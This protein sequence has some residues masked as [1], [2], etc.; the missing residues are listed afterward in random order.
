MKKTNIKFFL[1]FIL[2]LNFFQLY[3]IAK[4]AQIARTIA[5]K[6]ITM[7]Y[8]IQSKNR[9]FSLYTYFQNKHHYTFDYTTYTDINYQYMLFCCG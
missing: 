7:K 1:T 8:I 2:V 9:S 3:V 6:H 4:I 5:S